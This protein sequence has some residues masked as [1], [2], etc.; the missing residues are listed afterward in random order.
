[1]FGFGRQTAAILAR[2]LHCHKFFYADLIGKSTAE[3]AFDLFLGRVAQL[4]WT[5]S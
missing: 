4:T 2:I 5:D 1:M 3:F